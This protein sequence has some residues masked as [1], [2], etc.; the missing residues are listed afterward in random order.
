MLKKQLSRTL[1][2]LGNTRLTAGNL[3]LFVGNLFLNRT[4]QTISRGQFI[5]LIYP[6]HFFS[7]YFQ[8]PF[9]TILD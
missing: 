9:Y 6:F 2:T 8:V 3:V 4:R 1:V 5:H 7:F